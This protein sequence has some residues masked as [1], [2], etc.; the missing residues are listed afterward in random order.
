MLTPKNVG[1]TASCLC[2][3]CEDRYIRLFLPLYHFTVEEFY[4]NLFEMRQWQ[5]KGPKC[6][7]CL[8]KGSKKKK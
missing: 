4:E 7:P 1:M 3:V 8:K 6:G 2:S 5:D